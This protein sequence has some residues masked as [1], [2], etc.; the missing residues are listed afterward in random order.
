MVCQQK[1]KGASVTKA[2]ATA[3]ESREEDRGTD[4]IGQ[5]WF[6]ILPKIIRYLG[7]SVYE[8]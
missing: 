8:F 2:G 6:A 4:R 5:R 3:F 1:G 7:I